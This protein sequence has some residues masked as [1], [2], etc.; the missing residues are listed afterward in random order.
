MSLLCVSCRVDL[1]VIG[2]KYTLSF[3][4]IDDWTVELVIIAVQ[5]KISSVNMQHTYANC[6]ASNIIQ[7]F[8]HA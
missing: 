4:L 8:G 2:K 1:E 5:R 3:G 7:I 6:V